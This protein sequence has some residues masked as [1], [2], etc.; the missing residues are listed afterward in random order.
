MRAARRPRR[1]L[2][3]HWLILVRPAFRFSTTRNAYVLRL[4]G[5][6]LG[7]VL[8]ADRRRQPRRK[9]T[10]GVDRRRTSAA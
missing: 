10:D 9:Q 5:N 4:I 3:R 8:R 7:P 6:D 2:A 1:Y